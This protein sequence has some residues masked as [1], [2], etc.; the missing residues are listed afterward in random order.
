M[1]RIP[2][3]SLDDFASLRPASAR[4][5]LRIWRFDCERIAKEY[6]RALSELPESSSHTSKLR[7]VHTE[8]VAQLMK[9]GLTHLVAHLSFTRANRLDIFLI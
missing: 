6:Y 1:E 3:G 9:N 4:G 5:R 2:V 8:I 7:F